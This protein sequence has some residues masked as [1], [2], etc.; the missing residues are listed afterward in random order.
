M[1]GMEASSPVTLLRPWLP[2]LSVSDPMAAT[3]FPWGKGK[4]AKAFCVSVTCLTAVAKYLTKAT[5]IGEVFYV[6]SQGVPSAVRHGEE[7]LWPEPE[8]QTPV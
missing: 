4:I 7:P 6:S 1:G 5:S 2:A 3:T 8:P